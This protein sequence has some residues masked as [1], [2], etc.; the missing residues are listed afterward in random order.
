MRGSNVAQNKSKWRKFMR[1]WAQ[2]RFVVLFNDKKYVIRGNSRFVMLYLYFYG[3]QSYASLMNFISNM[4]RRNY[5]FGIIQ[6]LLYDEF[7]KRV[8]DKYE[9]TEL[10][11]MV[12]RELF[13]YYNENL[14][15][16]QI[17]GILNAPKYKYDVD[18][19]YRQYFMRGDIVW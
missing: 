7:V 8:D 4:G 9:L 14:S 18:E 13:K 2:M 16:R 3:A 11:E 10:G 19:I 15:K 1:N 6:K 5:K 17:E 12:V